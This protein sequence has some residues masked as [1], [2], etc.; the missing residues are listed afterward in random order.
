[1]ASVSI[2]ATPI[3]VLKRFSNGVNGKM[4][5][6]NGFTVSVPEAQEESSEGY[7]VLEHNQNFRLRL[8]NGHKFESRYI[9]ADAE[10]YLNGTYCGTFRVPANQTITLEH[11]IN[12]NGKF[13][14]IRNN[15]KEAISAE[16]KE[17]SQENGLIKVVWKPG[18]EPEH[19]YII[20]CEPI[21]VHIYDN[22]YIGDK[23]PL[24]YNVDSNYYYDGG[25]STNTTVNTRSSSTACSYHTH[26]VPGNLVGGGV[27]LSGHSDQG[28]TK[29]DQLNY[30]EHPTTIYLRIAFRD[31]EVRPLKS[32][33]VYKIHS[34]KVPRPLK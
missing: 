15:T 16:L 32:N 19:I 29:I 20:I 2:E 4:S 8:R 5:T 21:K 10:V 27:G 12:D 23:Y 28:F 9:P 3:N 31:S 33:V 14:A 13:T 11:P 25:Y 24:F 18:S 34:T 17:D 1:V 7:I 22:D 6:L 30:S 26:S